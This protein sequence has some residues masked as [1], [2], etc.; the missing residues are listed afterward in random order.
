MS[1]TRLD[2]LSISR[3]STPLIPARNGM[4]TG[5]GCAYGQALRNRHS[6]YLTIEASTAKKSADRTELL[7]RVRTVLPGLLTSWLLLKMT[8]GRE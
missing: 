2:C 5:T 4:K 1:S 7:S 8:V 6:A 3:P